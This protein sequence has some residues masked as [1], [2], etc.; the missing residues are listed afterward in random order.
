[1]L[2]EFGDAFDYTGAGPFGGFAYGLSGGDG[3]VMRAVVRPAIRGDYVVTP[4]H[5]RG[6]RQ[7]EFFGR[8]SAYRQDEV[9][10]E[11]IY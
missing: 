2:I 7:L 6:E 11:D 10:L 3:D 5:L 9:V 1:M 8:E 4:G